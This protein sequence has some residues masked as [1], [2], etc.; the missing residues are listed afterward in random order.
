MLF[1]EDFLSSRFLKTRVDVYGPKRSISPF[2]YGRIY[3]D[4]AIHAVDTGCSL[5]PF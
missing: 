1:L 3:N 2:T 4:R 5:N